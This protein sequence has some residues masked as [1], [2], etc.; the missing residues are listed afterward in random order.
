MDGGG[1]V[2][3]KKSAPICTSRGQ[4]EKVGH[5]EESALVFPAESSPSIR[6]RISLFPKILLSRLPM[7]SSPAVDPRPPTPL[8][9]MHTRCPVRREFRAS[10]CPERVAYG[11]TEESRHDTTRAVFAMIKTC[12][13][14]AMYRTHLVSKGAASP[15]LSLPS[16]VS[17]FVH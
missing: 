8:R 13:E 10:Q 6:T 16:S 7:A 2:R 5:E 1:V 9:P 11:W 14:R 15:S 4:H 12:R 3:E 17:P